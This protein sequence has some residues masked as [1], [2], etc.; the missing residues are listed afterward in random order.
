M[1][2]EK[3]ESKEEKKEKKIIFEMYHLIEEDIYKTFFP[4][5]KSNQSSIGKNE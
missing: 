3:K 1:S 2:E 4:K 5:K